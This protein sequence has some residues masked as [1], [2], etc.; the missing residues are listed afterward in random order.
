MDLIFKELDQDQSQ[1]LQAEID[2]CAVC[3]D[4]HRSMTEALYVFDQ[5]AETVQPAE[6]YWPAYRAMLQ[7][8][9]ETTPLAEPAALAPVPFWKRILTISIPIPAPVA[10]AAVILLLVSS[11]LA[12]RA[13]RAPVQSAASPAVVEKTRIVEVPVER[14]VTQT[15]YV[16][17]E[18]SR[19][20]RVEAASQPL[21]VAQNSTATVERQ[22]AENKSLATPANPNASLADF[23]PTDEVK[24]TLI[25]G[26]YP[27]EK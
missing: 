10:A 11:L 8:R 3:Q 27:N 14:I 7:Q 20:S 23:K 1:R 15:V 2:S 21:P 13:Q 19:S 24:L 5:V 12:L 4:Q 25:K 6:D 9:L 22:K 16:T 17:K 18:R 26:N